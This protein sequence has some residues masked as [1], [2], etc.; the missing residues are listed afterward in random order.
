M[1]PEKNNTATEKVANLKPYDK[2]ASVKI[3]KMK[4]QREL[5]SETRSSPVY[6]VEFKSKKKT[7]K[8]I[9]KQV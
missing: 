5:Y 9:E 4:I 7:K 1:T 2:T 8:K 6:L 3:P